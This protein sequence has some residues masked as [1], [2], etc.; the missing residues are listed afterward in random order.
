MHKHIAGKWQ[1]LVSNVG[2]ADVK[3]CGFHHRGILL[4]GTQITSEVGAEK[5]TNVML[6]TLGE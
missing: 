4:L 3:E 1:G 5:S 2:L 6:Y